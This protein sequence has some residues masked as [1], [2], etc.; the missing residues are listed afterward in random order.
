MIK[1]IHFMGIGGSGI[2]GVAKLAEKMGY[3]VSGCDLEKTTAYAENMFEGHNPEHLTG[4]D[5][6]VVSPA[7]LYQNADNPEF[8]EGQRRKIVMTWQEFLG[9]VLLQ[10][11]KTI[12]IAGTHGKS[13]TTAMVGKLLIDN[14]FDPI[15]VV[16]AEVPGWGGNS[17]YGKGEYAVIEADEFN[18]NFLNYDPEIAVINNVEFDHPDFFKSEKEV[19][20]SFKKFIGKISGQKIL[21]YNYD[22]EGIQKLLSI[23]DTEELKLIPYSLKKAKLDFKLKVPGIHNISNALGTIELGKVLGIKEYAIK[24]SLS[25]FSGIGRRMELIADRNRIK[26]YDDYA[27]HPTAIKATLQGLRE[28]YPSSRIWAIDEPHGFARTKALLLDYKDVFKDADKVLIGPIFKARDKDTFGMTPELIAKTSCHAEAVG[29]DSFDQI[30]EILIK[31]LKPEDV[32]LVMGAGKS[33]IW[34]RE[35]VD[36]IPVRF[37]DLTTFRT[38]GK[39]N[40]YIEVKNEEEIEKAIKFAKQN[41]LSIFVIGGGSDILV[42]DKEFSGLVIKY[43]AGAISFGDSGI[44]VAEAGADWD[45]FV[46]ECVAKGLQGLE[47]LSGIPGTVGASR[48]K[49][50]E[51]TGLN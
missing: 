24:E 14:G 10:N 47:C 5:L 18:N 44:V 40:K 48:F 21:I 17:R 51:H 45:E 15:V 9:K 23:T 50:S 43:T 16:G 29:V 3:E 2:S 41:N 8:I 46:K 28:L 1:K 31:E 25:E 35:I 19:F 38:G 13:T 27:H 34:A 26:V 42:S 7:I 37:S 36:L 39:I 22:S 6:L 49:I 11:K 32:V 33:Y 20:D 30:K 4:V 12:C